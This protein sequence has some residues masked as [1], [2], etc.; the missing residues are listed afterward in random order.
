MESRQGKEDRCNGSIYVL[1]TGITATQIDDGPIIRTKILL[2]Q[3]LGGSKKHHG[4]AY[5]ILSGIGIYT[6]IYYKKL[7][8]KEDSYCS[9]PFR[10]IVIEHRW[11]SCLL[12][13][14]VSPCNLHILKL[15]I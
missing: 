5:D 13:G 2:P 4:F 6:Y 11:G 3:L 14:G 8:K 9:L 7:K 12:P 15:H 10:W 1:C